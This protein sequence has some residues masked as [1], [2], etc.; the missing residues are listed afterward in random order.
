MKKILSILL[1][2]GLMIGTIGCSNEGNAP[3]EK[4]E[5]KL[6]YQAVKIEKPE[7]IQKIQFLVYLEDGTLR[8]GGSDQTVKIMG[9]TGYWQEIPNNY[10]N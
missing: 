6:E 3:A 7:D 1:A 10:Q 9:K 2:M 4:K 5:E 8:I